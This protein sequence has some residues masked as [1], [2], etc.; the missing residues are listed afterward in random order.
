[1]DKL[2]GAVFRDIVVVDKSLKNTAPIQLKIDI[3]EG[4]PLRRTY[5]TAK[6]PKWISAE[7]Y[8]KTGTGHAT[9]KAA[10]EEQV[11]SILNGYSDDILHDNYE[12]PDLGTRMLFVAF[13]ASSVEARYHVNHGDLGVRRSIAFQWFQGWHWKG[14]VDTLMDGK[15]EKEIVW[16][17]EKLSELHPKKMAGLDGGKQYCMVAHN[18]REV[19]EFRKT[20]TFVPHTPER[21]A[22][23]SDF[24]SK[25]GTLITT[26]NQFMGDAGPDM[27]DAIIANRQNLLLPHEIPQP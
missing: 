6:I 17:P 7:I 26:L 3:V 27:L 22:F 23:L 2:L 21:E 16:S 20:W 19:E 9:I 12:P 10:S 11:L 24:G 15:R 18:S 5:F 14:L 4:G 25:I 13:K 8:K 1:M